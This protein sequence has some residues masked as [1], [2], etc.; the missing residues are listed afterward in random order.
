MLN[1]SFSEVPL[2]TYTDLVVLCHGIDSPLPT[3]ASKGKA[4]S[5]MSIALRQQVVFARCLVLNSVCN[6]GRTFE[7]IDVLGTNLF[8]EIEELME[9]ERL[10]EQGFPVRFS[11]VGHS[12]GGLIAR[13]CVMLL[14][15]HGYFDNNALVP[16]SYMS[17]GTPHLS[18]RRAETLVGQLQDLGGELLFK[19]TRTM[20]QLMLRDSDDSTPLLVRMSRAD[21]E[22]VKALAR[23]THRTAVSAVNWDH[24]VELLICCNYFVVDFKNLPGYS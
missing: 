9:K 5:H 20:D 24:Q 11:I 16:V 2:H 3:K 8:H 12:L 22:W 6:Y 18:V 1:Q 7:G 17:L 23:F 21:G 14:A 13:Y 15:Q 4:M 10:C 19:G